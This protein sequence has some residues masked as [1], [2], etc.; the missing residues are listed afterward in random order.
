MLV[1]LNVNRVGAFVSIVLINGVPN[2]C[3]SCKCSRSD[4]TF[5]GNRVSVKAKFF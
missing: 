1:N 3:F 5:K 2:E 4:N